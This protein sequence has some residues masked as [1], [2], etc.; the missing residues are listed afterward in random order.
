MKKNATK[1]KKNKAPLVIGIIAGV[2][3]A[4]AI[5]CGIIFLLPNLVEEKRT[6]ALA[7][8][9]E[10]EMNISEMKEALD[11]DTFYQGIIINGID[12]SGKSLDEVKSLMADSTSISSTELLHIVLSLEGQNYPLDPEGITL[13]SNIDEIVDAAYNYGR[14]STLTDEADALAERMNTIEAL[15][16]TPKEFTSAYTASTEKVAEIVHATLDPL[17]TEVVEAYASGFDLVTLS[18]IIEESQIG[19]DINTDKAI[20]DVKAALDN[21]QYDATI[22][23]EAD[24]TYPNES[25][26]ELQNYLG[27][28]SSSTSTTT[29]DDD[30]NHN[31][32]LICQKIDGLVLQ[33]GESFNFNDYIGQRTSAAGFREAGGIFDG[34][35]R[36]ELGGGICQ[37]NTMIFHSV[38]KA[39]LQV[40]ERNPHSWPSSYVDTGTDATVTWGG[41]NFQ[42]TNNTDYPIALHAYYA[43]R[44]VT[45]E[46]YGRPLEDGVTIDLIGVVNSVTPSTVVEYVAD[47]T[48]AVG[49]TQTDR[50]A[51]S[52]I[53][54]SAYKVYYDAQG[55][56][57]DRVLAFSS[58]YRMINQ[59]VRVGVLAADGSILT[60]DPTT[61]TVIIPTPAVPTPDPAVPTPDPVTPPAET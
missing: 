35:L 60:M 41:A 37:A 10:T 25:K 56:E 49:T 45:V 18:F 3:V 28:I 36:Q 11:V 46:V 12:V 57:I 43:D 17:N 48:L 52:A 42:F 47:P 15:K 30:R 44:K 9:S 31:I 20:E 33:P 29:S 50:N 55:N 1:K 24:I 13:T 59:R 61:G 16:A 32:N 14:S 51:H 54:A 27:L 39:D 53:N 6:I 58:N 34:A 21:S 22:T 26:E 40:D 7:D 4:A 19:C 38:V 23:V 8:G 2:V 5:V